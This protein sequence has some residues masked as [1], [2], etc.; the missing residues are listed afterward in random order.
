MTRPY[1]PEAPVNADEYLAAQPPVLGITD[2]LKK[3]RE[4]V[5]ASGSRVIV[6]DNDPTGLQRPERLPRR[7]AK[8]M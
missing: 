7:Y 3:I 6:L 2:A 1:E 5:V 4:P 8:E